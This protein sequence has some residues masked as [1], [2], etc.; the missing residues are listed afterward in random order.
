MEVNPWLAK[1]PLV[2]NGRLANRG[3]TSFVKE[4]PDNHVGT[5]SV[6]PIILVYTLSM[7]RLTAK[8]LTFLKPQF[9]MH[10]IGRHLLYYVTEF[11]SWRLNRFNNNTW[12]LRNKLEIQIP[13]K[14]M[15]FER[16]HVKMS[17]ILS[18]PEECWH[19]KGLTKWMPFWNAF[20]ERRFFFFIFCTEL[21]EVCSLRSNRQ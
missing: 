14:D 2:F 12:T 8:W 5:T 3:L 7:W 20:L 21:I 15:P 1:R 4:T 9:E 16:M 17:I 6:I 11:C 19:I 13:I 18:R 10:I